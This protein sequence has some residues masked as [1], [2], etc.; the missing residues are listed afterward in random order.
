LTIPQIDKQCRVNTD[1]DVFTREWVGA[2]ERGHSSRLDIKDTTY[3]NLFCIHKRGWRNYP[4][5]LSQK[6]KLF[7]FDGEI[8]Y[9]RQD[10]PPKK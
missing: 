10:H 1:L 9:P 5:Y 4:P 3:S 2:G 8:H 7:Y 6:R